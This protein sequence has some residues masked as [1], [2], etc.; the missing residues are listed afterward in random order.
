MTRSGIL[1][2]AFD[3]NPPAFPPKTWLKDMTKPKNYEKR[4]SQL[5]EYF[6]YLVSKP[7]ILKDALFQKEIQLPKHLQKQM[8]EIAMDL[9]SRKKVIEKWGHSPSMHKHYKKQQNKLQIKNKNKN[10]NKNSN[11]NSNGNSPNKRLKVQQTNKN[12]RNYISTNQS[13]MNSNNLGNPKKKNNSNMKKNKNH[14]DNLSTNRSGHN[15]I[16]SNTN[17]NIGNSNGNTINKQ[18]NIGNSKIIDNN[19]KIDSRENNCSNLNGNDSNTSPGINSGSGK[20]KNGIN[21]TIDGNKRIVGESDF[22]VNENKFD[23]ELVLGNIDDSVNYFNNDEISHGCKILGLIETKHNYSINNNS[24]N[25][26]NNSNNS[27]ING[28]E[29]L[30]NRFLS[31]SSSSSSSSSLSGSCVGKYGNRNIRHITFDSND[32]DAALEELQE[33]TQNEFLEDNPHDTIFMGSEEDDQFNEELYHNALETL[34]IFSIEFSCSCLFSAF[35]F[36]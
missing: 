6:E 27:K 36:G 17:T 26:N 23:N 29:N 8:S 21:S 28:S 32:L 34:N 14:G 18:K 7:I 11:S 31:P 5:L 33:Q 13:H 35:V 9:Q 10:K 1:D 4:A 25:N 12:S 22:G 2:R 3:F 16:D 19:S 15:I 20:R 30:N 24:N